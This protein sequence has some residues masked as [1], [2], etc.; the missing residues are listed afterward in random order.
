MAKSSSIL[1]HHAHE[2][3]AQ[4]PLSRQ[5]APVLPGSGKET[6]GSGRQR[7]SS[8]RMQVVLALCALCALFLTGCA[9]V[10]PT[11]PEWAKGIALAD[12]VGPKPG[13]VHVFEGPGGVRLEVQGLETVETV[14]NGRGV[15]VEERTLVPAELSHTGQSMF[16]T[17][18]VVLVAQDTALVLVEDGEATTVLDLSGNTWRMP[19]DTSPPSSESALTCIALQAPDAM[20]FGRKRRVLTAECAGEF[21]GFVLRE[22]R[23]YAQGL[24]PVFLSFG[25]GGTGGD[26]AGFRL[27]EVR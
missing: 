10:R 3:M 27:V 16:M 12:F 8:T 25:E 24:G 2:S 20:L 6:N 22:R 4:G 9:G 5:N 13:M 11:A 14:D 1:K 21:D 19:V 17:R 18:Q 26:I 15:L 7:L 23:S